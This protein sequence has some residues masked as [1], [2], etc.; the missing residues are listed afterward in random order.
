MTFLVEWLLCSATKRDIII[1]VHIILSVEH[2]ASN[3]IGPY[4][5]NNRICIYTTVNICI[6]AVAPL[7]VEPSA[8]QVKM[9]VSPHLNV[10]IV[11]TF[12]H[13]ITR[14]GNR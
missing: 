4:N 2:L 11:H 7:L 10:R 8:R 12:N 14:I 6:I 9:I 13:L 1:T 5:I 3:R